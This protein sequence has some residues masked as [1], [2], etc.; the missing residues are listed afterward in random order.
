VSFGQA[1]LEDEPI[2]G[3]DILAIEPKASGGGTSRQARRLCRRIERG[4]GAFGS[5]S[6]QYVSMRWSM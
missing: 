2:D 6:P 1:L 3:L 5:V 4:S